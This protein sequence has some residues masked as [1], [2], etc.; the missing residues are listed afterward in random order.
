MVPAN[1]MSAKPGSGRQRAGCARGLPTA[2]EHRLCSA[3]GRAPHACRHGTH[4]AG[5]R[6]QLQVRAP[7]L[8]RSRWMG[9]MEGTLWV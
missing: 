3:C 7:L 5:S 1:R 2:V 4:H 9:S 8:I 6:P